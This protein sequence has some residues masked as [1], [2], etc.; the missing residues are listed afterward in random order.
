M[1]ALGLAGLVVVEQELGLPDEN[2]LAVRSRFET[3]PEHGS[4]HLLGRNAI[5]PLGIGADEILAAAGHDIGAVAVGAQIFE[6]LDLRLIDEFGE[7][8][9]PARIAGLPDP[10]FDLVAVDLDI[11]AGQGRADDGKKL[12][13]ERLAI[14]SRSPERMALNA[15]SLA[16]SGLS[17]T[18]SG[19]R[20]KANTICV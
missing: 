15:S 2:R 6:Q 17:F 18:T 19:T 8:P 13:I 16:S 11:H 12:S 20:L 7:R 3:E 4:D 5:D 14:A 10:G 1:D 9:L